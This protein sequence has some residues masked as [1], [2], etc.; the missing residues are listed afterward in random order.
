MSKAFDQWKLQNF[1]EHP[2]GQM[3]CE[4]YAIKAWAFDRVKPAPK[5]TVQGTIYRR[6]NGNIR[7]YFSKTFMNTK[8]IVLRVLQSEDQN[9]CE[10]HWNLFNFVHL[11]GEELLQNG[12]GS[13]QNYGAS[14]I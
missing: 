3:T 6:C 9:E 8:L 14:N 4:I 11:S 7:L 1:T 2:S 5:T 10:L 13:V 12:G